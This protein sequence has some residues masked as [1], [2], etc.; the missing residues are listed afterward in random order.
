MGKKTREDKGRMWRRRR[1]RDGDVGAKGKVFMT[2]LSQQVRR[3][4][5]GRNDGEK[6][7]KRR[8][9]GISNKASPVADNE[10]RPR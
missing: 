10:E 5:D 8:S 4:K 9:E 7:G 2:I 3:N 6:E 1:R